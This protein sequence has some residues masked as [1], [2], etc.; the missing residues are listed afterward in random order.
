MAH[1]NLTAADIRAELAR[2]DVRVYQLAGII[3]MH[4]RLLGRVLRKRAPLTAELAAKIA[5]A[6]N[7]IMP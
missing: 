7:E 5:Q 2:R 6:F 3:R 1:A 4:P